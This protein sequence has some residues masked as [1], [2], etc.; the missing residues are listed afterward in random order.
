MD[1]PTALIITAVQY[2]DGVVAGQFPEPEGGEHFSVVLD[3]DSTLTD[4]VNTAIGQMTDSG[5]L[6]RITTEEMSTSAGAPVFQP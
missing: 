2:S 4:C 1:L 6:A 3:K 5:E